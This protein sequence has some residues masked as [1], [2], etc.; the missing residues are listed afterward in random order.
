MT[1]FCIQRK[2]CNQGKK[3]EC[4]NEYIEVCNDRKNGYKVRKI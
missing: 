4:E 1:Y 3:V 2:T